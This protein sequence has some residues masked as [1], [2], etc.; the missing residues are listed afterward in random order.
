MR[1]GWVEFDPES[2]AITQ[3]CGMSYRDHVETRT[4]CQEA[5]YGEARMKA[6]LYCRVSTEVQGESGYS[7]RQQLE[8]LRRYCNAHDLEVVGQF[9][10][11]ASGV[12]LDRLGLDALRDVVSAGS[13]EVVL[14]R[15]GIGSPVS[16]PT[17]TSYARNS[18]STVRV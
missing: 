6:A 10:D 11:R 8:A 14:A 1:I 12:S 9:E 5:V 3:V 15:I 2:C 17:T 4:A 18:S 16:Q 13:I 7:L